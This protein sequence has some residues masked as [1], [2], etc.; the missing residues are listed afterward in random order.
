[1][2]YH[3]KKLN[4]MQNTIESL[5][6]TKKISDEINN[7]TFHHHYYILYDIANLYPKNYNI[8]YVEIGC[9]AGG[10]AC[11]MLQ[12]PNTQVVSIDLGQPISPNIVH[13]N[14]NKLNTL[15]NKYNYL[16][17]NSQTYEMV[18]QLKELISEIDILFIDGDHSY[19]GTFNDFILYEGLVKKG[20]YIVFDDYNDTQHNPEVK[21]VVND[22]IST[23]SDR[24]NII[25]TLPNIFGARPDTLTEGNDYIIQKI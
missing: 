1:M 21:L 14:V 17:G 24:Y 25:G 7:M 10:S 19:Q 12:R 16:Q 5:N 13:Q 20:G 15:K 3:V 2:E 11:L 18:E 22:I 4:N 8:T 23:I 9:Y 6:L